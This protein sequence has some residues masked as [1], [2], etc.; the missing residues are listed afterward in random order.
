MATRGL[1]L[2]SELH[3]P[4]LRLIGM[5]PFASGAVGAVYQPA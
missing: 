4:A 2:F 3:A 5:T 1:P